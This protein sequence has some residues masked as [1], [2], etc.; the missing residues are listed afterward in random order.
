[1]ALSMTSTALRLPGS[2][3]AAFLPA[4]TTAGRRVSLAVRAEQGLG[5]KIEEKTKVRLPLP[6]RETHSA[7]VGSSF[8][9]LSDK[10][11]HIY[12]TIVPA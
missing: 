12:S 6:P 5:E 9:P 10:G 1:M 11:P 2:T 8:V 3:K 7:L 4:R